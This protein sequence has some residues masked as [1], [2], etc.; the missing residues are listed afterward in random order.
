MK[1]DAHHLALARRQDFEANSER[2]SRELCYYFLSK[3][4]NKTLAEELAQETIVHFLDYMDKTG[5]EQEIHNV[6]AYLIRIGRNLTVDWARRTREEALVTDD[7][8]QGARIRKVLEE[9]ARQEN[10]PTSHIEDG[11][12]YTEA[13]GSVPLK[14][15]LGGLTE[16]ELTIFRMSAVDE[17]TAAEIAEQVGVDVNTVRHQLNGIRVKVRYRARQFLKQNGGGDAPLKFKL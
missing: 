13:S 3:T 8:E 5:W 16:Y 12:Y 9:R 11:I 2:Y 15:I 4:H 17:M 14:V 1:K 7:S 6:M 10:D